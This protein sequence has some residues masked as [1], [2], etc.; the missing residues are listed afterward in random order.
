MRLAAEHDWGERFSVQWWGHAALA[1]GLAGGILLLALLAWQRPELLPLTIPLL[2]A[3]AAATQLVTRPLLFLGSV[4]VGT[5]L[6]SNFEPGFQLPELV[7]A[8]LLF[9]FLGLWYLRLIWE[10]DPPLLRTRFDVVP[11][12]LAA[13]ITASIGLNILFDGKLGS[14]ISEWVALIV[15]LLYYPLRECG[16]TRRGLLAIAAMVGLLGLFYFLR[17][18][19]T[20]A[21]IVSNAEF[22]WQVATGRAGSFEMP[23]LIS[24]IASL[25]FFLH[26]RTTRNR[27]LLAMAFAFF[28]SGLVLTQSRG[29]W[30]DFIF[31]L[32]FLFLLLDR[33]RQ[34]RIVL[35]IVGGFSLVAAA[36]YLLLGDVV[37]LALYGLGERLISIPTSLTSDISLI[38]RFYESKAVLARIVQNPVLGY[39]PGV[40]Y[41]T[42][43]II[44]DATI[45]K[46]FIHNGLLSVWYRFGLPGLLG[47]LTMWI[48]SG[49][50]AWRSLQR[51]TLTSHRV[52]AMIVLVCLIAIF[53]SSNTSNPFHQT[54]N[55]IMFVLLCGWAA[56]LRERL[57]LQREERVD[58]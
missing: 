40:R 32:P 18:A 20:Y 30:M 8:L 38:N 12:L 46:S 11:V 33:Q 54:H 22:A 53:P 23:L 42:F 28:F 43:D 1:A 49:F 35:L 55:T 4:V 48:G 34:Y 5:I 58:A 15:L 51:A 2:V 17:N 14:A 27:M 7:Y 39:G 9:G 47:I 26:A 56:A 44:V 25:V 21:Q 29:Y 16:R 19:W 50:S 52:Q 45:S 3:L 37:F 13:W 24:S 41:Q 10:G 57:R 31:A 36:G 6:L